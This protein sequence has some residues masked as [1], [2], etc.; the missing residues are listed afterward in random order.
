LEFACWWRKPRAYLDRQSRPATRSAEFI[1]GG[2]RS[3]HGLD[4]HALKT[5]KAEKLIL[6]RFVAKLR[7]EKEAGISEAKN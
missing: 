2:T 1:L 7:R 6:L 4:S 5:L 3:L